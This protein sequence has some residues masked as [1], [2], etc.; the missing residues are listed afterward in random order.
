M[1]ADFT[2]TPALLFSG[3]AREALDFYVGLFP[4]SA[5]EFMQLYGP[6]FPGGPEGKVAF[7]QASIAG[8]PVALMDSSVEQPFDFTP[9]LSLF[10]QVPTESEIDRIFG[11]LAE[12]GEVLMSLEQYPFAKKYGWVADRF[13]VSWQLSLA[14]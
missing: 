3:N 14:E 8:N 7:A 2:L 1:P 12:G 9:A 4:D 5:V 11:T 10:V 13:G 6:D